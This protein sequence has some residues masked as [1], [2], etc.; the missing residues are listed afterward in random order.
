MSILRRRE[1]WN[2]SVSF[3]PESIISII[4]NSRFQIAECLFT[5]MTNFDETSMINLWLD[6]NSR[7][8]L[9][10]LSYTDFSKNLKVQS[11]E[12]S[13]F[14]VTF[15]VELF[16]LSLSSFVKSPGRLIDLSWAFSHFLSECNFANW[17]KESSRRSSV[18][19]LIEISTN[20]GF[21]R[22]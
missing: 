16:L 6:C 3:K 1:H 22:L 2:Y 8:L 4:H 5:K 17:N 10:L 13:L 11:Q 12:N 9:T 20:V 19:L 18:F 7:Q 21:T 14:F 15:K